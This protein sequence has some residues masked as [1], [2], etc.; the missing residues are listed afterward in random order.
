MSFSCDHCARQKKFCVVS[1][2]FN[3]YSE[4]VYLKKLCLLF[5]D[6]LI[7]NVTWLLKACKKIEEEQAWFFWINT[8]TVFIKLIR[9]DTELF[10][11]ST[12]ITRRQHLNIFCKNELSQRKMIKMMF[13]H[14]E[15]NFLRQE[16]LRKRWMLW[17]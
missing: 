2:K 3:K 17:D 9:N 4:Y 8:L 16:N 10:L 12:M 6:S 5:S 7:M 13:E 15:K 14:D 11:S 1:N